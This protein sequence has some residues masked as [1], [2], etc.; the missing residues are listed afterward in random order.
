MERTIVVAGGGRGGGGGATNNS[1]G[2]IRTLA[3]GLN[4]KDIWGKKQKCHG[5]YFFNDH[6]NSSRTK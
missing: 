1:G 2:I 6:A 5:S 3:A 4:Y